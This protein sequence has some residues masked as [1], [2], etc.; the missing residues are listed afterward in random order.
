MSDDLNFGDVCFVLLQFS[1]NSRG[2]HTSVTEYQ[3]SVDNGRK[4]C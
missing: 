4:R 2:R 3:N 1:L